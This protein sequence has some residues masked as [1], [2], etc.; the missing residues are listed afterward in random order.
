MNFNEKSKYVVFWR[1][2]N[3]ETGNQKPEKP[4][5]GKPGKPETGKPGK[6]EN[7]FFDNFLLFMGTWVKEIIS[8][9]NELNLDQCA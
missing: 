1:L 3:Q 7:A 8:E 2:E 4:D 9:Q 6:P 5:S